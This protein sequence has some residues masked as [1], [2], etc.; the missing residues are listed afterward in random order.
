MIDVRAARAEPERYREALA[1][2]GAGESFDGLMA[3]DAEYGAGPTVV[4]SHAFAERR[5]GGSAGAIGSAIDVDGIRRTVIGV[6]PAGFRALTR[7]GPAIDLFVP[8][9]PASALASR[10]DRDVRVVGRLEPG[11]TITAAQTALDRVS[12]VLALEHPETNGRVVAVVASLSDDVTGTARRALLAL[13][14]AV[15]LVVLIA[16]VNV[17]NLLLVWA[18]AQARDV[19]IRVTLGANRSDILTEAIVRGLVFGVAGAVAGVLAGVWVRDAL[20]ALAP[21]TVVPDVGPI[22]L[23][24]RVLAAAISLAVATGVLASLLPA[25]QV[26][27]RRLTLTVAEG[28][29]SVASARS[30]VR[31]RGTLLAAEVAAAV[32]LALGAGLLVRSLVRAHQTDLGFETERVMAMRVHLPA[33]RYPDAE[34]RLRFFEALHT[35]LESTPGVQSAAYANQFPL[36]GGWGGAILVER[37]TGPV[38]GE[39]DLQA[40]SPDYFRVLD[41]PLL[42]GRFFT[43]ADRGGTA[44]AVIVSEAF[45]TA[46]LPDDD[47]LGRVIRRTAGHPPLT[48]VGVVGDVRRDGKFAPVTPQVYF[49]AGQ[50]TL[51]AA[52][53]SA[54]A[55]KA[56]GDPTAVV[57]AIRHAV[58]AF[59]PGL[60]V[61]AIAPLDDV[62]SASVAS[63]R[64]HAWLFTALGGLALV[65]AVLGVYGVVTYVVQQRTREM[66]VRMALGAS[67][68]QVLRTMV[69]G[70]LRWT[71]AGVV[72]GMA[73]AA[74]GTRFLASLL[75]D[76][77]PFDAGTFVA[78][79]AGVLVLAVAAAWVPARRALRQNPLAALRSS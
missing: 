62:V 45:V 10:G 17:A 47:P 9:P 25:I 64:F 15:G 77:A 13:L 5:F 20:L 26:T 2:K 7:G 63:L 55:I 21:S 32:I 58:A 73:M 12:T 38:E 46:F 78:V 36:L 66:G 65:L 31:W 23:N 11:V 27:R 59:D 28:A 70:G 18:T 33:L 30:I 41:M 42:R 44:G 71:V 49:A 35:H 40:V 4:V 50:T 43:D 52:D 74:A 61:T 60:V 51:Y 76:T 19:A 67:R 53:L 75:F 54:V 79:T 34:A 37:A 22:G 6:L 29:S 3:A 14:A 68:A 16:S 24:A 56:S 39:A 8:A 1:R 48:I 57:P 69:G 72:V